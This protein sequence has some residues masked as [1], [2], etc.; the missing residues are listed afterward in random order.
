M[1][2][3]WIEN[4]QNKIIYKI[5]SLILQETN[6]YV[7]QGRIG[8]MRPTK[9]I[10]LKNGD[11]MDKNEWK[12]VNGTNWL[13]LD[14]NPINNKCTT[15]AFRQSKYF[16]ESKVD[17][18]YKERVQGSLSITDNNEQNG[19]FFC[20]PGFHKILSKWRT[21]YYDDIKAKV[22]QNRYQFNIND[23]I[24]KHAV[25]ITSRKGSLLIWNAKLPHSNFPNNSNIP[26]MVQFIKYARFND[27][28]TLPTLW[29]K[30][31]IKSWGNWNVTINLPYNFKLNNIGKKV[32][33]IQHKDN[34]PKK[35]PQNNTNDNRKIIMI[36]T[37]VQIHITTPSNIDNASKP[38]DT[39]NKTFFNSL[40]N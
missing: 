17:Q 2:P 20:V 3:Q 1:T 13:H 18:Y 12:T 39:K 5:F 40:F 6:I 27:P 14:Y 15:F 30:P 4:R 9:N 22:S 16:K 25:K 31:N 28:S 32:F 35:K 8:Y 33:A 21:I 36:N 38:K 34:K 19:G 26:R 24:I 37:N 11:I 23:P 7:C 10:K 29:N